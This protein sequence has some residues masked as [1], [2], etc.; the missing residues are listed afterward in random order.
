MNFKSIIFFYLIAIVSPSFSFAQE[1]TT[2]TPINN[3]NEQPSNSITLDQQRKDSLRVIL[4]DLPRKATLRS[5]IIPG[6]GQLTNKRWWKVPIIYGAL[7]LFITEYISARKEYH[8]FLKEAQY[9]TL[10]P[11]ETFGEPAYN[12]LSTDGIIKYKDQYSRNV[13]I[14]MLTLIGIYT[15]NVI[16]AYVDA[17]FFRFDISDKLSL[18]IRPSFQVTPQTDTFAQLHP[19]LKFSLSL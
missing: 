12:G 15:F 2:S 18:Q 13:D 5:L 19:S 1:H 11:T 14:C 8:A 4:N 3:L 6:W 16:D 17:K 10:N 9:R 7:Y